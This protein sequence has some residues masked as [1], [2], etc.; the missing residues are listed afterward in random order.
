M[1][2][3][4]EFGWYRET[5][6]PAF[7]GDFLFYRQRRKCN[8]NERNIANWKNRISN[9]WEFT[10]KRNRLSTRMGRSKPLCTTSVKK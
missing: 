8:E 1:N 6:A 5:F 10:Y 3:F 2:T 7:A 4:Q 9:A